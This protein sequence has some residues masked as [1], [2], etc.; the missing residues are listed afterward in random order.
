MYH[1]TRNGQRIK[2]SD[3][4]N[5]HLINTVRMIARNAKGGREVVSGISDAWGTD[6][7]VEYYSEQELLNQLAKSEYVKELTRRSLLSH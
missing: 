3:M 4:S 2:I 1:T 7:D 5:S 6:A